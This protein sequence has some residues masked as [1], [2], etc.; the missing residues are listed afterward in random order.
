MLYLLCFGPKVSILHNT[1]DI[2]LHHYTRCSISGEL[3]LSSDESFSKHVKTYKNTAAWPKHIVPGDT[4]YYK[5]T[6]PSG[7]SSDHWGWSFTV[8]GSQV[9]RFDTGYLLLSNLLRQSQKATKQ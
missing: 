2:S 4:V 6:S 7:G 5:V 1:N 9:G 8:L 3:T